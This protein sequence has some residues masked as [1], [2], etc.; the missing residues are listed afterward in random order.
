MKVLTIGGFESA[1]LE[2]LVAGFVLDR[3]QQEFDKCI[4]D[5]IYRDDGLFLISGKQSQ[6]E[7]LQWLNRFQSRVDATLGSD[8]LQFMATMWQAHEPEPV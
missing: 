2:D 4:F 1:W 3:K 6:A 8:W 5:G 7:I